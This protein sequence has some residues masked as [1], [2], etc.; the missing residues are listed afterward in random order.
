M[1]REGATATAEELREFLAP[2]FAKWWLPDRV[3]FVADILAN[4]RKLIRIADLTGSQPRATTRF[5]LHFHRRSRADIAA[6]SESFLRLLADPV[7]CRTL[8]S[9]LPWDA[10]RIL[11]AFSDEKPIEQVGRAFVHQLTRLTLIAAETVGAKEDEW[12]SF[13]DAPALS[14]AAFGDTYLNRHYLPWEGLSAAD[15][16]A[17]DLAMLQRISHAAEL[18]IDEY[19]AGRFS[20]KSFNIARLQESYEVLSRRIYVMKKAGEDVSQFANV[21]A[22]SVKYIVEATRQHAELCDA[23]GGDG[24]RPLAECPG[25]GDPPARRPTEPAIVGDAVHRVVRLEDARTD[26]DEP[27]SREDA[28]AHGEEGDSDLLTQAGLREEEDLF[29]SVWNSAT[30]GVIMHSG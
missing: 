1:L 8:V 2:N 12:L 4:I 19:V 13:S 22:H 5:M 11:R 21:L 6:D 7:F 25:R 16:N 9:R 26:D 3:E 30:P 18:T 15:L 28:G 27:G 23:E 24:M 20:Y 14:K 10:A 17:A 29:S